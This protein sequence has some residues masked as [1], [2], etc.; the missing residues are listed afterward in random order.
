[1]L[2]VKDGGFPRYHLPSDTPEHVDMR[3]VSA[4]LEAAHAIAL[5]Q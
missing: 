3:C 4:C 2:S 1:V 5:D